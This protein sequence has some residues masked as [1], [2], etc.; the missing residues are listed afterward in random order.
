[1]NRPDGYAL[2]WI[3]LL[4]GTV[5]ACFPCAFDTND[6][7]MMMLL[8]SG[9]LTGEASPHLIYTNALIGHLLTA[10]Y[11]AAP[12]LNWYV[13]YLYLMTCVG[14]WGIARHFFCTLKW[15]DGPITVP[16]SETTQ[17]LPYQTAH[18]QRTI[19]CLLT[20]A[21]VPALMAP[22]YSIAAMFCAFAGWMSLFRG[23]SWGQFAIWMLIAALVRWQAAFLVGG[24]MVALGA[25]GWLQDIPSR[26]RVC[27]RGS[28]ILAV[29]L[30]LLYAGELYYY[31]KVVGDPHVF[32][33]QKALDRVVNAPLEFTPE[34]LH[35]V[36]WDSIDLALVRAWCPLD[37]ARHTP[38]AIMALSDALISFRSPYMILARM[39]MLL[40]E[41]GCW[42]LALFVMSRS[43]IR[44]RFSIS[45]YWY[46]VAV[47][48][49]W[50][51]VWYR[52][53]HRMIYPLVVGL[54]C[55]EW[56]LPIWVE[57]YIRQVIVPSKIRFWVAACLIMTSIGQI[58][59]T[60]KDKIANAQS[61]FAWIET[62]PDRLILAQGSAFPYEGLL[63]L[64][65]PALQSAHN[66]IPTGWILHSPAGRALFYKHC[67]NNP[68]MDIAKGQ[69]HW[70]I[71]QM[72]AQRPVTTYLSQ[73]LQ[74][75]INSI[76]YLEVQQPE[77]VI[78]ES[79]LAEK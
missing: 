8:T 14:M 37:T 51:A 9:Y 69:H 27:L 63:T 71:W 73:R 65:N 44:R 70:V 6:D 78:V 64:R 39:Y 59:L 13:V 5:W 66:L 33:Y 2:A 18:F 50:G 42:L 3:V 36:G 34:A 46:L 56:Y 38:Q 12:A 19:L 45:W 79:I 26:W 32:T 31:T 74:K 62:H 23:Q 7:A 22:Q 11:R 61:A 21:M 48:V 55:I 49:L 53:P 40:K 76:E 68:I 20:L 54:W 24:C 10:L 75:R 58:Y 4:A 28:L 47:L 52:V 17:S 77:D 35:Q 16:V 1:M 41:D 30:G 29:I 43:V 25:M 57:G 15:G 72:R 60:N 67:I